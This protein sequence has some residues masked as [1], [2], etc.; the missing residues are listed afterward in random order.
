MSDAPAAQPR[1]DRFPFRQKLVA[2]AV[3]LLLSIAFV[4]ALLLLVTQ[5]WY[6]GFLFATDGGW[7]G[8]RIVVLVD[9]VL[10]PLLTF[11][12]Y[13]RGKKGLALDLSLIA[14][15]QLTALCGGGWVVY[16]ERPLVLVFSE[17]RFYSVTTDDYRDAG[18]SV[19]DLAGL[20]A[21][22]PEYVVLVPPPSALEQSSV[23]TDYVRRRQFIYSHVPWMREATPHLDQ[24][25]AE[26]V[27]VDA[28][29]KTEAG[30]ERLA[31]WLAASGREPEELA[32]LPYS[33]R[34]RR[35]FLALERDSG[36]IVDAVDVASGWLER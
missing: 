25:L 30:A 5:S 2:T 17:G 7:Q 18:A 26:A 19:P 21:R 36:H 10:G 23:R 32:F 27:P 29:A 16:A 13:K 15:M 28:L 22:P 34:F 4:G 20:P 12:V 11:V 24:V 6:P 9:L 35:V 3:H 8:L 31:A 14:L 33:S 1:D